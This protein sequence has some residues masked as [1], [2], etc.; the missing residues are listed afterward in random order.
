M[1]YLP[2]RGLGLPLA[3]TKDVSRLDDELL[4]KASLQAGVPRGLVEDVAH[5]G[6][7]LLA[8]VVL[9]QGRIA[10]RRSRSTKDENQLQLMP[11]LRAHGVAREPT[12]KARP[13]EE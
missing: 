11:L 3:R 4:E 7:R 13:Q 12:S 8:R 6:A 1:R 5:N 10:D 2:N 9:P